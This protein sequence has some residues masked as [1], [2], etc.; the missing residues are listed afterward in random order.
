M[1]TMFVN[2]VFIFAVNM[3]MLRTTKIKTT[4]LFEY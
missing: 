1:K 4:T 3:Q 2:A